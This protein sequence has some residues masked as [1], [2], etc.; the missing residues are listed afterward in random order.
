MD[1]K[2]FFTNLIGGALYVLTSF[3]ITSK[4]GITDIVSLMNRFTSLFFG[5]DVKKR[6]NFFACLSNPD[7]ALTILRDQPD[8]KKPRPSR[9]RKISSSELRS[10]IDKMNSR[11]PD[12]TLEELK[13]SG[14]DRP[15]LQKAKYKKS[16]QQIVLKHYEEPQLIARLPRIS[17]GHIVENERVSGIYIEGVLHKLV[18]NPYQDPGPIISKYLESVDE[19]HV[20]DLIRYA[21]ALEREEFFGT[22]LEKV[23]YAIGDKF[24]MSDFETT[25]GVLDIKC[26]S[27]EDHRSPHMD[28]DWAQ[29]AFYA[30]LS[31]GCRHRPI[32]IYNPLSGH[33]YCRRYRSL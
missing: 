19:E 32:W 18:Q 27:S 21:K 16:F 11:E 7:E 5:K 28:Y 29:V 17:R 31:K 23:T 3:Q 24:Y 2:S 4:L 22:L 25:K 20:D 33:L 12:N 26:C 13:R 30:Y 9:I 6:G 1:L 15:D 10:Q 14:Y 8:V